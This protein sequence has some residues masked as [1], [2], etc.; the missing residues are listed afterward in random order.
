MN[1]FIIVSVY[2]IQTNITFA[3][4]KRNSRTN[5][6]KYLFHISTFA[7]YKTDS[8]TSTFISSSRTVSQNNKM[9]KVLIVASLCL[10]VA[11][12]L[13]YDLVEDEQGQHYYLVPVSR[14]RR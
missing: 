9:Q 8:P 10:V 5:S 11:L 4:S 6:V 1:V 2:S 7:L 14:V 13:P 3:D 12:A